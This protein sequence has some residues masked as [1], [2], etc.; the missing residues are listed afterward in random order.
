TRAP[1]IF[2]LSAETGEKRKLTSPPSQ[3]RGDYAPA[4]SPDGRTLAFVRLKASGYS[5]DILQL[6]LSNG[7]QPQ[8]E[9]KLVM[10]HGHI[11]FGL[12]WTIDG[13]EIIAAAGVGS[14]SPGSLWRIPANSSGRPERIAFTGDESTSPTLSRQ[15]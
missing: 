1:G 4:F 6:P 11:F 12:A 10:S 8:G 5:G 14:F 7:L 15:G 2:L 3:S 13:S 9:P